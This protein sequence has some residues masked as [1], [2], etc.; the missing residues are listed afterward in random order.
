MFTYGE[1]YEAVRRELG[2][3]ASEFPQ[4]SFAVWRSRGLWPLETPEGRGPTGPRWS[5]EDAGRLLVMCELFFRHGLDLAHSVFV[6]RATGYKWP[7]ASSAD[8][9]LIFTGL[10]LIR[11]RAREIAGVFT[12]PD[13]D[14]PGR[15]LNGTTC[16]VVDAAGATLRMKARLGE[17]EGK[18][19]P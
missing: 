14:A 4:N 18:G 16:I 11:V 9:Y 17:V 7:N 19:A 12:M 1:I 5:V 10:D 6:A 2:L 3:E 13:L 15:P 8:R